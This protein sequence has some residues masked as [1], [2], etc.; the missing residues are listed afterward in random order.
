MAD[1][2]AQLDTAALAQFFPLLLRGGFMVWDGHI[3]PIPNG[4][5]RPAVE[6]VTALGAMFTVNK[7][8]DA[9]A[10]DQAQLALADHV[11]ERAEALKSALAERAAE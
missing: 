6:M 10:R 8:A 1:E 11:I 9:S 2:E 4:V 5:M 3:T 7:V